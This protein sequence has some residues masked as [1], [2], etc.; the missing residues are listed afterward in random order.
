MGSGSESDLVAT[1]W[2]DAHAID[3]DV[4]VI[5]ARKSG[6]YE[7]GHI[8]H[9]VAYPSGVTPFLKEQGAVMSAA[10]FAA[11]M[12]QL[13]VR[14]D[15]TVVAYDD[16]KNLF[17][18]RLWWVLNFYGHRRVKGLDG[19]WDLCGWPKVGR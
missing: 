1:A 3:D 15:T 4:R 17:A 8:P 18:G 9:A 6:A 14:K 5:D 10:K 19:G 13:G 2:L 16:G 7:L 11:L 12:S